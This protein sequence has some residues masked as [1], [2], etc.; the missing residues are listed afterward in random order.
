VEAKD[1]PTASPPPYS[2]VGLEKYSGPGTCQIVGKA[3]V[4]TKTF[5][6]LIFAGQTIHLIPLMD[7]SVWY[8]KRLAELSENS[9]LRYPAELAQFNHDATSDSAG[10]FSFNNIF[11]GSYIVEMFTDYQS[12]S[13]SIENRTIYSTNDE[14]Y[15]S[16]VTTQ[17]IHTKLLREIDVA[18]AQGTFNRE[19]EQLTLS[20]F[21]V[22]GFHQCCRGEL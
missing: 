2:T 21:G 4:P 16:S 17:R 15:P 11:C 7:Y 9:T 13:H 10:N 6:P 1:A 22:L 19:G 14:D 5:G 18:A 20:T 8:V 3:L 12:D